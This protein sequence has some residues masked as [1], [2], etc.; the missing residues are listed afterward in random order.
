MQL[1]EV[2]ILA[3]VVVD[4]IAAGEVVERPSSVVKELVEN[5]IDANAREITV[6]LE[7]GGRSSIEV[8]DDGHGMR[9]ADALKAVERF[10]TSKIHDAED[11][12]HVATLGFRGEALPSIASVS[13]FT[14]QTRPRS[15]QQQS[16]T[17][18]VI[19]G[20]SREAVD[21]IACPS[22]SS[23]RV[24]S[25]F[26]NVPARKKF[27]RSER[28]EAAQVKSLVLDYAAAYPEIRFK[29][30]VD[31]REVLAVSA[32]RDFFSR[33]R[34]LKFGGPSAIEIDQESITTAG[35][36]QLKAVLSQP[37]GAIR[38]GSRLRLI[39]N[40]RVVRDKLLLRA[41]REG[42]GTFLKPG[43][44]PTGIVSLSVLP[45]TI[46][47]NVHPQ[48]TEI[49]FRHSGTVFAFLAKAVSHSLGSREISGTRPSSE[50]IPA[51]SVQPINASM[52]FGSAPGIRASSASQLRSAAVVDRND[53]VEEQKLSSLKFIG[54]V[55]S[56]YLLMERSDSV[57]IVDMHAAHERIMYARIGEQLSRGAVAAQELLVPEVVEAPP[58]LI[59]GFDEIKP[60][61][62]R[63][64]ID[65][66][67]FGDDSVVVRSV[68]ALLANVS[69]RRLLLDICSIPEWANQTADL[70]DRIKLAV[71]RLACHA[72]IRSGRKLEREEVY[73][74]L[75]ELEVVESG[76]FCPHGRPVSCVLTHFEVER[77]FGR[78]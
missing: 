9:R 4:Q 75:E 76:A 63:L 65:A 43:Q 2:Q 66:E 61:L 56:C 59:A 70:E 16:G 71:A 77:M 62:A 5:A 55:F 64:G 10:G 7:S 60:E 50:R 52:D 35:P 32:D 46:D 19:A 44:F 8:I 73:H 68:P 18:V 15:D 26:Y 29:L 78:A 13:K 58:E 37:T 51:V 25:L 45:E 67:L 20:G 41:V 14:L 24:A 72:S 11:L 6:V 1:P 3:D 54:Q 22:G 36:M 23:V 34:Q 27:M 21:E 53:P 49:R 28:A 39:V 17:R 38:G 74:L 12:T 42:F 57:V 48:K 33:A 40:G 30:V 69:P 31:G 47:V